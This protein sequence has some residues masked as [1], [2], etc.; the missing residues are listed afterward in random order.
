MG[1]DTVASSQSGAGLHRRIEALEAEARARAA[2]LDEALRRES[3]VAAILQVIN[4][5]PGNLGPVFDALL[6]KATL[7]CEADAGV[8]ALS[9]GEGRFAW[10][11]VRGFPGMP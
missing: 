1:A 10:A 9:Q 8:F 5:S 7:L 4:A 6:E 11:S 2:D 3:A